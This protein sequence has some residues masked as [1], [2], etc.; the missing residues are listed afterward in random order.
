MQPLPSTISSLAE[1][2]APG[3]IKQASPISTRPSPKFLPHTPI[4]TGWCIS[5]IAVNECPI[6]ILGP[7]M[8]TNQGDMMVAC[9]PRASH[10]GAKNHHIHN[11]RIRRY[12][13]LTQNGRKSRLMM[14]LTPENQ[15]PSCQ[16]RAVTSIGM[17]ITDFSGATNEG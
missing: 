1:I 4:C 2:R 6:R 5:P 14:A 12:R 11:A 7:D 13:R 10:L 9:G 8:M 16:H 15:R 17:T 3:L